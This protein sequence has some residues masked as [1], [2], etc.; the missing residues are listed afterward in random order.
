[1][2]SF[3]ALTASLIIHVLMLFWLSHTE[4]PAH[5]NN[6]N[7]IEV[8]YQD[9]KS[10][11]Q[12]MVEQ[13]EIPV[14]KLLEVKPEEKQTDFLSE[15]T[16][17]V[18]E[19]S[20]A[21]NS[22]ATVN[23]APR[24]I[25]KFVKKQKNQNETDFGNRPHNTSEAPPWNPGFSANDDALPANIRIG[26]FTALNTDAHLFY[27]FFAR[28]KDQIR[29]RWVN[30]VENAIE[31]TRINDLKN[32]NQSTW[33]T[34]IEVVLDKDGRYLGATVMKPSGLPSFDK[35]AVLAFR[36]GAPFP[37]P[38]RELIKN[39]GK[40]YLEYAFQVNWDPSRVTF[41]QNF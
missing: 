39:D 28:I 33:Q 5:P 6:Y 31:T 4:T 12:Q 19:E 24:P 3:Q 37:N 26:D 16:V 9:S 27:T 13:T 23:R 1:M 40:I 10:K 41:K 18:K 32:H 22:G 29:Y 34:Y 20:Q 8:V 11:K 36:D 17:R 14:D 15:K 21:R 7:E 25:K 2:S 38:P 35:A 30:R